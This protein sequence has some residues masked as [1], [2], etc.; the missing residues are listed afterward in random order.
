M[1]GGSLGG[2]VSFPNYMADA[3][4]LALYGTDKDGVGV[5]GN[6]SGVLNEMDGIFSAGTN[7]YTAMSAENPNAAL[8]L[9]TNS[10]MKRMWDAWNS[11]DIKAG[12]ITTNA[13]FAT[14]L[15]AAITA[16]TTLV[17]AALDSITDDVNGAIANQVTEY[18]TQVT[19]DRAREIGS[20]GGGMVDINATSGSAFVTGIAILEEKKS[21]LVNKFREDL[22]RQYFN[23]FI[24]MFAQ[25]LQNSTGHM[26]VGMQAENASAQL[27][28]EMNRLF[29]AAMK[30]QQ[31]RDDELDL[32]E[33]TFN[34]DLY[35][36]AGNIL[37]AAGSGVMIPNRPTK[38]QSM[39]SGA[40]TGAAI[41]TMVAPGVGTVVGGIGGALAGVLGGQ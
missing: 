6:V 33:T 18:T 37:G 11:L 36:Y 34:L 32:L 24:Q 23:A 1:G 19:A 8:T 9:V 27:G 17:Q 12:E 20:F 30:D 41:G 35:Q 5:D 25:V 14:I 10:P 16:P 26:G 2:A 39:M 15:A 29:V 28:V 13:D 40:A 3:H 7:P 4:A 31:E 21:H 38:G 22:K